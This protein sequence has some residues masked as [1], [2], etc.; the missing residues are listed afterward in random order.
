M[1]KSTEN[2]ESKDM[3]NSVAWG[4]WTFDQL[5]RKWTT[6]GIC[7]PTCHVFLRALV[8][9]ELTASLDVY[10]EPLS[11]KISLLPLGIPEK[12]LCRFNCLK[13]GAM[14]F[15]HCFYFHWEL[16]VI[17]EGCSEGRTKKCSLTFPLPLFIRFTRCSAPNAV[18]TFFL[19]FLDSWMGDQ[20]IWGGAQY[21]MSHRLSRLTHT[22][23]FAVTKHRVPIWLNGTLRATEG[24]IHWS[25]TV[26]E[27]LEGR[28]SVSQDSKI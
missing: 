7:S 23:R 25:V 22:Q 11:F 1:I 12:S 16:G 3:S 8:K 10:G 15:L 26:I 27:E 19:Q 2:S 18:F 6:S 4:Y 20:H 28:C 24:F 5:I 9:A 17:T 13:L 21:P 14:L